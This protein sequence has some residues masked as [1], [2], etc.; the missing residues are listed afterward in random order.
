MGDAPLPAR[1]RSS[2]APAL[3]RA[4]TAIARTRWLVVLCVLM[5]PAVLPATSSATPIRTANGKLLSCPDPSVV[6]ADVGRYRYYL[7]CTSDHQANAFPIRGSNDLVHWKMVSYVFPA[8]KQ[9]WWALKSP[10]G[11]YWA[12]AI[13]RIDG[14]WIVYFAAEYNAAAVTLR[15]Q[16]GHRIP[17]G[18][19]VIGAASATSL[20][21]PWHTEILHYRSQFNR[22]GGEQ[23]DY[24]G[25]IDPSMVQNPVTGQRYLFWAEQ[26]SSI[27]DSAL[28]ADGLT[29]GVRI[30]QVLW[31]KPSS[32]ECDTP[33]HRCTI[34]GPEE[35]YR[36]GWF[37]LFYSGAST[38]SGTYAV[39]VALAQ[40]PLSTFTRLSAQPILRSGH[41]WLGP[42]GTSAPVVAPDGTE[43]IFYHAERASN[44]THDSADRYLFSS[45][46]N[47]EGVT[48]ADPIINQGRA[49]IAFPL[50]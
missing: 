42:G 12:P 7:A 8:H 25:V 9:P 29:L 14:R 18:T 36:N 43:D 23:E 32:W 41:G 45:P 31:T 22:L 15:Y 5:A 21:G 37:Y 4:R 2:I 33:N 38:W 30:H 3:R 44:P 10:K 48:G 19:M 6:N 49:G 28:S 17:G 11:R 35:V 47:W 40:D 50:R 20:S 13:Y 39:G 24:G 27:W 26:H 46:L 34:E 1:P 16:N